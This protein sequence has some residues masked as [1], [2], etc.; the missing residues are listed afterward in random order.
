MPTVQPPTIGRRVWFWP[1]PDLD[2]EP[3]DPDQPFDA[4]VIYVH[5]NGSVNLQ[6]TDHTGRVYANEGVTLLN[7]R[8]AGCAQ[9]MPYQQAQ[10]AKQIQSGGQFGGSA[11]VPSYAGTSPQANP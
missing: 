7:E 2:N 3:L 4:G 1:H 8:Q 6:I 10:Q 5:P 11:G 9:W